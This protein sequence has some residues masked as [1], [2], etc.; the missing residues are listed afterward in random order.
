MNHLSGKQDNWATH[1]YT[2]HLTTR[3]NSARLSWSPQWF[4]GAHLYGFCLSKA[5]QRWHEGNINFV[6]GLHAHRWSDKISIYSRGCCNISIRSGGACRAKDSILGFC[7]EGTSSKGGLGKCLWVWILK[8]LHFIIIFY[9]YNFNMLKVITI[10]FKHRGRT[11]FL[12]LYLNLINGIIF[13][14]AILIKY[15]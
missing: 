12:L 6:A 3:Q 11:L 15:L 2:R 1:L 5:I 7:S 8:G 14:Q 4:I 10:G 13:F 9:I